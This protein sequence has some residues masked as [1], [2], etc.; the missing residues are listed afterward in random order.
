MMRKLLKWL[1]SQQTK[2]LDNKVKC[3]MIL[4]V[5]NEMDGDQKMKAF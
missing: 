4:E 2:E 1:V 3:K 5:I